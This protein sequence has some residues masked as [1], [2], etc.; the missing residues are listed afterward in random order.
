[1]PGKT[2]AV[3]TA[4]QKTEKYS[5]YRFFAISCILLQNVAKTAYFCRLMTE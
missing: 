2:G 1:V 5:I 4:G 3:K